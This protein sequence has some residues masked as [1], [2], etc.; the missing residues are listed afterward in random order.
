MSL[1]RG[2]VI[3]TEN[4]NQITG[5]RW[6]NTSESVLNL[7]FEVLLDAWCISLLWSSVGHLRKLIVN[8]HFY[9]FERIS[10]VLCF[11]SGMRGHFQRC[12]AL[13]GFPPSISPTMGQ[14]V[15]R[16]NEWGMPMKSHV[17]P[18]IPGTRDQGISAQKVPNL[19]PGPLLTFS[20]SIVPLLP[21]GSYAQL[22]MVE[23]ELNLDL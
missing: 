2:Q 21:R 10:A 19:L 15:C 4:T 1:E 12:H 5:Q 11:D 8:H 20:R 22:F 23:C 13:E 3:H 9:L 17:L 14:R 16:V 6:K 7:W 18:S